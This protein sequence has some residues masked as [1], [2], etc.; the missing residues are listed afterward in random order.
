MWFLQDELHNWQITRIEDGSSIGCSSA[1][2]MVMHLE[3][4]VLSA[5]QIVNR[6][7]YAITSQYAE[8]VLPH[9]ANCVSD[10]ERQGVCLW[11]RRQWAVGTRKS[12]PWWWRGWGSGWPLRDQASQTFSFERWRFR[13]ETIQ[14]TQMCQDALAFSHPRGYIDWNPCSTCDFSWFRFCQIYSCKGLRQYSQSRQLQYRIPEVMKYCRSNILLSKLEGFLT[15]PINSS[16][17]MHTIWRVCCNNW[18]RRYD[19]LKWQLWLCGAGCPSRGRRHA[20]CGPDR[21]WPS[22]YNRSQWWSCS[23]QMHRSAAHETCLSPVRY[24]DCCFVVS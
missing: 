3:S 19:D 5:C 21:R 1:S 24:W 14:C 23:W 15:L 9:V 4:T 20:F 17:Q 11:A 16:N 2:H 12:D 10:A 7:W 8:V 6:R 22:V 18:W 13:G